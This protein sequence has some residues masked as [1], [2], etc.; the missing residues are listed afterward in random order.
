[1][2]MQVLRAAGIP[3][4]GDAFPLQWKNAIGDANPHGFFESQFRDGIYYRTNPHPISGEFLPPTAARTHAVKVFPTGLVRSD[5]GYIDR[6]IATIRPWRSYVASV[7]R[8][9][10]LEDEHNIA[11]HGK[12]HSRSGLE[13]KLPHWG[14]WWLENFQ[15]IRDIATR[16]HAARVLSYES[17]LEQ[18]E[19]LIPMVIRWLGVGD[20]QQATAAVRPTR[21]SPLIYPTGEPVPNE[22][23]SIV[24]DEFYG[25]IHTRRPITAG[26][27]ETMND[28]F[29]TFA[30]EFGSDRG[31]P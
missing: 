10:T 28:A 4:V 1:M 14:V 3:I 16:G 6:V 11:T 30:A 17:V 29:E 24:F 9:L 12:A 20:A 18:P 8:L 26:L 27:I 2:W 22:S 23:Y 13:H 21:A 25:T 15:L 19:V 5:I 7:H 31:P